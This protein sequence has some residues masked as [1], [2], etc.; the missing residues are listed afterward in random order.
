M[1]R[2]PGTKAAILAALAVVLSTSLAACV[3]PAQPSVDPSQVFDTDAG[4]RMDKLT[5]SFT[6]T[7]MP[8]SATAKPT[9]T[10]SFQGLATSLPLSTL[11]PTQPVFILSIHM[12]T[13]TEGF[14]V[15]APAGFILYTQDGGQTWR[16]ITPPDPL[17]ITEPRTATVAVDFHGLFGSWVYY[18]GSDRVWGSSDR[19][20]SWKAAAIRGY[21][22]AFA[23]RLTFADDD[24]GW[25]LLSVESGMGSERVALFRTTNRGATW[26]EIVNPYESEDLQ[27]CHK[28]GIAFSSPRIGWVTYDCQ[29]IYAEAFLD[30][31]RD[32]G[33]TWQEGSLPIP[34]GAASSSEDGYCSSSQPDP[35]LGTLVV[36]CVTM[37]GESAVTT[38]FL[39]RT[40]D[41]GVSWEILPFPGGELFTVGRNELVAAGREI[42]HSSDGGASWTKIK[43]VNWD[44]QFNFSS[45]S[46]AWAVARSGDEIAFVTSTD[47]GRTWAEI[48]P[49]IGSE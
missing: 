41:G 14:A 18:L 13:N 16:E 38:S 15:A 2:F 49:R 6:R 12:Q 47:G 33:L 5:P 34:E 31:T 37:E 36:E 43:T 9:L 42:Y 24:H 29:G 23:A 35:L 30:I 28:T 26:E 10:P 17:V 22:T 44:G 1:L 25:L 45:S 20:Q 8:P 19:G 4:L 7:S 27:S 3:G 32:G 11:M 21:P 46:L 40:R 48:K 39:Y